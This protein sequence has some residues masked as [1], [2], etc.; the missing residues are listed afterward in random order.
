MEG[1][2]KARRA[3]EETA[4]VKQPENKECGVRGEQNKQD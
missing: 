3:E 1:T 2:E 4:L